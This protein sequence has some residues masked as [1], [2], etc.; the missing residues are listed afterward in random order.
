MHEFLRNRLAVR[1]K[2]VKFV[3]FKRA[4]FYDASSH[5]CFRI[6]CHFHKA[7]LFFFSPGG[8]GNFLHFLCFGNYGHNY[9]PRTVLQLNI[10]VLCQNFNFSGCLYPGFCLFFCSFLLFVCLFFVVLVL[11]FLLIPVDRVCD[12]FWFGSPLKP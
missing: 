7:H 10:L 11:F 3:Q 12:V 1:R 5:S 6:F 8:K 9:Y 2:W 4:D